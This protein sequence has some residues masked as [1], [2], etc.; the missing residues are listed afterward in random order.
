[1]TSASR[2]DVGEE[3]VTRSASAQ[4]I[5]EFV[6]SSTVK[7]VFGALLIVAPNAALHTPYTSAPR[8]II[9]TIKVPRRLPASADR[10][11]PS[12]DGTDTRVGVSTGRLA[13]MFPRLFEPA[14]AEEN[15]DPIFL[16]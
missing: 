1:V 14:P 2:W 8:A 6:A 5:R 3:V 15:D 9:E 16:S 4:V 7:V 12:S 10:P 11:A 13:E